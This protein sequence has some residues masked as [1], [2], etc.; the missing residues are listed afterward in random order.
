MIKVAVVGTGSIG[1]RHLHVLRSLEGVDPIAIPKRPERREALEAEGFRTAASLGDAAQMG[2]GFAVIASDTRE[3]VADAAAA[4]DLKMQVLVEKPLAVDAAS[5]KTLRGGFVGCMLRFSESLETFRALLPEIG[6]AYSVQI[7]CQSYLPDWRPSR[8]YRESY[9]AR[10]G[11]GGVLRDLIHEIDYAGWIF[12]WPEKVQTRLDNF[13]ILNID[14]EERAELWWKTEAGVCV[15]LCLD[16]LSRV[17]RRRMTAFGKEGV[18]EWNA[19]GKSVLLE[20][21]GK[22]PRKIVSNQA[23]DDLFRRQAKAFLEKDHGTLATL[24]EG[25]CALEICDAARNQ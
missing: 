7:E 18:L 10:P 5:A 21:P 22:E 15:S 12:G 4:L 13:G 16:Y 20:K 14:V 9:S 24:E 2:A 19:I 6:L 17:P 25:I 11:E 8:D 23:Y 3:H 1:T